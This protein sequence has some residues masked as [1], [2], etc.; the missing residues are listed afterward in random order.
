M[1][2]DKVKKAAYDR[3][4]KIDNRERM[5]KLQLDYY[6]RHREENLARCKRWREKN[7]EHHRETVR[8]WRAENPEKVRANG[9]KTKLRKEYG[10]TVEQ[11]ESMVK[12]QQSR[13]AICDREQ[14]RLCVDH[15]HW[16]QKVRKLLCKRCNTFLGLIENHGHLLPKLLE[17]KD[18]YAIRQAALGL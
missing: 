10:I 3:Q 18:R 7:R 12:E 2:R 6:Y 16:G 11:Y 9:W 8:K 1:A 13:C 5:R 17:Y 4:Y 15:D 14:K